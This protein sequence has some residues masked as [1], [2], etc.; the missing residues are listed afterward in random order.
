MVPTKL[1]Q[2]I[3]TLALRKPL[4][5]LRDDMR[6]VSQPINVSCFSS[7]GCFCPISAAVVGSAAAF[8]VE[9]PAAAVVASAAPPPAAIVG[10]LPC[11]ML[12]PR[13]QA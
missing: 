7:C 11:G 5:G 12:L 6:H 9:V 2:F 10:M 1:T 13:A 4:H 3:D 8:P